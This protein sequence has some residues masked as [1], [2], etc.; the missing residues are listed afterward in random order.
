MSYGIADLIKGLFQV[1]GY[2]KDITRITKCHLL[3]KINTLF[4]VVR[5]LESSN[6]SNALSSKTRTRAIRTTS[7]KG[8]TNNGGI[9]VFDVL[10][11]FDVGSLEERVDSS[12]VWQFSSRERRNGLVID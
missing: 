12:K 1:G 10:D 7:I 4:I 9:V 5:S 8:Y 6:S 2:G 3:P 11:V